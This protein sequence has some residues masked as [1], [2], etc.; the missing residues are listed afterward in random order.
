M[1]V[2]GCCAVSP[3]AT[4]TCTVLVTSILKQVPSADTTSNLAIK[5]DFY[6][7][8][9][10]EIWFSLLHV[11]GEQLMRAATPTSGLDIIS[12]RHHGKSNKATCA[13]CLL[14]S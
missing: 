12:T 7:L 9:D 1:N 13:L 11:S 3:S 10:Q 2:V 8:D 14:Y 4:D 6:E 5:F